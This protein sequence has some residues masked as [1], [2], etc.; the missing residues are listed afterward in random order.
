MMLPRGQG[1]EEGPQDGEQG[2]WG[3]LGDGGQGRLDPDLTGPTHLNMKQGGWQGPQTPPSTL[4]GPYIPRS[5]FI[6]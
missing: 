1:T 3:P 5:T 6:P 4:L 2:L